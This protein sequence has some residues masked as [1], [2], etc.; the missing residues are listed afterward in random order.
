[1]LI[2]LIISSSVGLLMVV[3]SPISKALAFCSLALG[4]GVEAEL[5]GGGVGGVGEGVVGLPGLKDFDVLLVSLIIPSWP[6]VRACIR[7]CVKICSNN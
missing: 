3:D 7:V 2:A 6:Q 1:M 5:V 4:V